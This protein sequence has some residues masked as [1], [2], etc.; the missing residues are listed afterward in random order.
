MMKTKNI[1]AALLLTLSSQALWAD[2]VKEDFKEAGR[3]I[4]D[5]ARNTGHAIKKTGKDIGHG[6]HRGVKEAGH[7][8][9]EAGHKVHEDLKSK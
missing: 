1:A 8:F 5:A 3:N 4:H 7:D 9:K 6:V 2:S